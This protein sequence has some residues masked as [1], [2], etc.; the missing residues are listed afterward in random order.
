MITRIASIKGFK[1]VIIG[2]DLKEILKPGFVYDVSTMPGADGLDVYTIK[3]LGEHATSAY[4]ERGAQLSQ[5]ITEGV[6]CLTKTEYLAQLENEYKDFESQATLKMINQ[7]K[8]DL[9]IKK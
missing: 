6:Y 7:L 2:R 1:N 5:T 3:C 9:K 4:M 8:K